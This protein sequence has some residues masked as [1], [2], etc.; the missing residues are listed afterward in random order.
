MYT[1]VESSFWQDEKMRAVSGDARHLMLYCLTSPHRNILGF[2][3]LPAPYA[4]FDLGWDEKRFTAALTELLNNKRI[5]YDFDKHVILV[6]NYLKHNPLG[7]PNQTTS[8]IKKLEELPDTKLLH[9][10]AIILEQFTEPFIEPL[11]EQ[12]QQRLQAFPNPSETLSKGLDNPS[13]TLLKQGTGTG[14]GTGTVL[15]TPPPP[16]PTPN[17]AG[18]GGGEKESSSPKTIDELIDGA[19]RYTNRQRKVIRDYWDVIRFTRKRGK[20]APSIV[21]AE[22]EYW[23][24]FPPDIVLEALN[25]HR[26]K[27]RDDHSKREEYTRGIMRRLQEE[28]GN[29]RDKGRASNHRKDYERT[30]CPTKKGAG[31]PSVDDYTGG[32]YGAIFEKSM[33]IHSTIGGSLDSE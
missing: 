19:T 27:Y 31:R 9:D 11:K 20:V 21:E 32:R 14:T 17:G 6:V 7:N 29:G 13:E 5:K 26:T 22:L 28:G 18:E 33:P 3:F 16:S 4:C 1:R 23:E 8:A 10:F 15:S 25:I 30:S 2:Y 24:R 12:L